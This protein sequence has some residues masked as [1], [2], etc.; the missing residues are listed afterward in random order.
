ML[1]KVLEAPVQ[2][3]RSAAVSAAFITAVAAAPV[4]ME[5]AVVANVAHPNGVPGHVLVV[6]ELGPVIN[7]LLKG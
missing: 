1:L 4:S 3:P 2:P 7:E 6:V 5:L